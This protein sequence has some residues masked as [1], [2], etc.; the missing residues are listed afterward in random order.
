LIKKLISL[1]VCKFEKH[2]KEQDN[3]SGYMFQKIIEK[4]ENDA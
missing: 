4:K 1:N 2:T 3:F